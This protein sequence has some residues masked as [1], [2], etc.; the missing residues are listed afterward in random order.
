MIIRH[1]ISNY[2]TCLGCHRLFRK[3]ILDPLPESECT[4]DKERE[5]MLLALAHKNGLI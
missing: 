3:V 2:S 5:V 4:E 1:D